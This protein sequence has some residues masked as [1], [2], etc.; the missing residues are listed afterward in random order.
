[1][2]QF[3][4]AFGFTCLVGVTYFGVSMIG[5]IIFVVYLMVT[6]GDAM[7]S[8]GDSEAVSQFFLDE[9]AGA[10]PMLVVFSALITLGLLML[11]F[12]GRKDNF[13]PYVG[14]RKMPYKDVFLLL[15]LGICL[16]TL[17]VP[18][19]HYITQ[20]LPVQ[21]QMAVY[22]Q[23]MEALFS[24]SPFWIFLSVVIAAPLIEEIML[25]GIVLNDFKKAVP[26][27]A[28]LIIQ[29]LLFGAMHM[30]WIQGSYACV[31]GLVLGWVYHQ[32]KSIWAPIAVHLSYN[33]TSALWGIFIPDFEAPMPVML[34]IGAIASLGLAYRLKSTYNPKLYLKE[35]TL[36]PKITD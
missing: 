33:M 27:W 11:Y 25:R 31:L 28:A 15:I 36:V 26:L 18:L 8:I 35:D 5:G 29:A 16:N 19:V 20:A 6:K 12:L 32:Y 30:N 9:I 1:M 22:N 21:E 13:I 34:A 17:S 2:K 10:T 24:G 14:F 7:G 3:L 4:K 23:L